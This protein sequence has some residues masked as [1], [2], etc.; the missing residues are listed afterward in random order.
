MECIFLS[1]VILIPSKKISVSHFDIIQNKLNT[2]LA[3][4]IFDE[5][6]LVCKFFATNEQ[7]KVYKVWNV[8]I[9]Q[10]GKSTADKLKGLKRYENDFLLVFSNDEICYLANIRANQNPY[11][12]SLNCFA[13]IGENVVRIFCDKKY[14]SADV[15][16]SAESVVFN[17]FSE[18]DKVAKKI[19]KTI[20]IFKCNFF[21]F[22]I[23]KILIF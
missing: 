22:F 12:S 5:E 18:F 3:E 20:C 11:S 21:Y 17:D 4:F 1:Y 13:L 7:K 6:D 15:E 23:F 2:L 19:K 8:G 10:V 16:K 9:K 14:I